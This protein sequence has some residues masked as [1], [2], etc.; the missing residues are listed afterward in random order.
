MNGKLAALCL[1]GLLLSC[2]SSRL[3]GES[4]NSDSAIVRVATRVLEKGIFQNAVEV[5]ICLG[6]IFDTSPSQEV[7]TALRMVDSRVTHCGSNFARPVYVVIRDVAPFG[8]EAFRIGAGYYC[9]SLC[10]DHTLFTVRKVG[11][12]W[13]ITDEI[14]LW[15]S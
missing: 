13:E 12:R 5:P 7:L 4:T 1:A 3:A 9:G 6:S 2:S 8:E 15:I 10:A 14:F 11:A